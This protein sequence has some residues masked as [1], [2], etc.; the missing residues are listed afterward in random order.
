MSKGSVDAI[1]A[2]VAADKTMPAR[3]ERVCCDAPF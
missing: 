1:E 2:Q 3:D